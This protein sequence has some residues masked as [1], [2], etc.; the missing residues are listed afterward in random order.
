MR[1]EQN[2]KLNNALKR[3]TKNGGLHDNMWEKEA[4]DRKDRAV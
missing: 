3:R 2:L 1:S 4:G